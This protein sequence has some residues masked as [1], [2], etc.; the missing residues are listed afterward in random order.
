VLQF[1]SN[2]LMSKQIINRPTQSG[3][4]RDHLSPRGNDVLTLRLWGFTW[5]DIRQD[6]GLGYREMEDRK[7]IRF[8]SF[9][10]SGINP[11]NA[12]FDIRCPQF[13]L[14]EI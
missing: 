11:D 8:K 14:E 13:L 9:K 12:Q 6:P 4:M 7:K 3:P 2:H 1:F 5:K 10:G